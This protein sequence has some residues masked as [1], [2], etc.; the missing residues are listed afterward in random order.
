MQTEKKPQRNRETKNAMTI[1]EILLCNFHEQLH[2]PA[3][4]IKR[5]KEKK[6]TSTF[7]A[8]KNPNKLERCKHVSV[9]AS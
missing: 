3:C 8:Q 9:K 6:K 5:Q 1:S 4:L 7:D 2:L